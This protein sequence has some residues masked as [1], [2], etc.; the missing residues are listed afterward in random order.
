MKPDTFGN[1][2]KVNKTYWNNDR[3]KIYDWMV[4]NDLK[5][6][7]EV[8]KGAVTNLYEKTPGHV[9][10]VA[11]AVRDLMNGMAATKLG[12]TRTQVKYVNLVDDLL[13]EWKKHNLPKGTET[14]NPVEIDENS[15]ASLTI[16][17]EVL[18]SV[19]KLFQEHEEGRRRSDESPFLFFQ[20]FLPN[21]VSRESLPESY[22][23]MWKALRR[24]FLDQCHE[25]GKLPGPE[26]INKIEAEFT[27]L[28]AI[29]LSV[30]DKYSNTIKTIDEILDDAN[31]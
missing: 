17:M 2:Q 25:S 18:L 31:G 10:F 15:P 16:P 27:Q 22:P 19:Q 8:Y 9:R 28:E 4:A 26:I 6:F 3:E 30:A 24:W 7:A 1:R 29:L 14:L 23:K 11:H 12:R 20:V 21:P 13:T 5:S